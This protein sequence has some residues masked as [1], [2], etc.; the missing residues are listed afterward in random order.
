MAVCCL[1]CI[2]AFC[3]EEKGHSGTG[4]AVWAATEL[5]LVNDY[6]Q[7]ERRVARFGSG[8]LLCCVSGTRIP[9]VVHVV[10]GTGALCWRICLKEKND[11][12]RLLFCLPALFVQRDTGILPFVLTQRHSHCSL[13]VA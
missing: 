8:C 13:S 1:L 11:F 7:D 9:S 3:F 4:V 5:L 2:R 6:E 12:V 10:S